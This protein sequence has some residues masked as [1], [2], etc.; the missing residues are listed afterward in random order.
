MLGS[1]ASGG[2]AFNMA[3]Y[4]SDADI[5]PTLA[6]GTLSV[7]ALAG[8][9]GSGIWGFLAER[10]SIRTISAGTMAVSAFS[11]ALL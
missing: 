7:F 1:L 9:V 4:F 8:A 2:I 6:A 11:L 3:A 10:F 5:D